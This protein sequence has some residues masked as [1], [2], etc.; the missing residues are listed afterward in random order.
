MKEIED[1]QDLP[2]K[3]DFLLLTNF[4][5]KFGKHSFRNYGLHQ[6]YYLSVSDLSYNKRLTS[7]LLQILAGL[8]SSKK[9]C[10]VKFLIFII[11]ATKSEISI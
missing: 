4:L 1:C 6:N 10:N 3:C 11:D 8:Y 5:E 9:V 7:N 2:L